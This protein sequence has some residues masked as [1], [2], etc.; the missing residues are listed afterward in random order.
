MSNNQFDHSAEFDLLP[1]IARHPR[2]DL[3][4]VRT[5][6][7]KLSRLGKELGIQ[8]Y[9]KRDDAQ[10][11]GMGGNKVRQLEYYLGPALEM[12]ADTVLI[13][14]AIQSNFVRLCSAAAR[15]VGL[16]PVVQL[17]DRVPRDD[18]NYR[19]SGNVLLDQLYGADIHHLPIGEDESAADINLDKIADEL[20]AK[21]RN[22]YVIHLG[23]EHSPLGGLG[24]ALAAA[25][26]KIQLKELA[27]DP[28]HVVIPT[29]SG[30]T[31]AGFLR[32]ARAIEWS[33]PI[34]GICVRRSADLQ[35]K[36]ILNR[37]AELNEMLKGGSPVSEADVI[38]DDTVLQPGYGQL[39]DQVREAIKLAAH[40]EG[41][42]LD[43]VYSGRCMAGLI[44][45][46][47]SGKIKQGERCLVHPYRWATRD[48]RL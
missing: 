3:G 13:T 31:H 27:L 45:L 38:V 7:E 16:H 43:P 4:P 35:Y 1:D 34:H 26:T 23:V 37:T 39:N 40:L 18:A 9:I 46:V 17:E 12:G 32:G 29:G 14:G 6:L 21:G 11:L 15:K 5:H 28:D 20:R 8:L 10:P 19:N 24:Y 2:V 36:R 22:P 42:L 44:E 25:E 47:R 41:I 30:L 48:I 33:V